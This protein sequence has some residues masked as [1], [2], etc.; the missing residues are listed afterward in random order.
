MKKIYDLVIIGAGSAGLSS[1]IYAGRATL[2]TLVIERENIGGQATI[3]DEIANYPGVK[4]TT[5]PKLMQIMRE[6]AEE[7][8]ANLL[9]AE[10]TAVDFSNE[11]KILQTTEEEIHARAVIIAS[12]AKPRKIG[13][14]GEQE[15]TGRGVGYCATCDGEF[16]TGKEVFVIGGGFS[17]AEEALFL[18]RY[19]TKVTIC[20]R[21]DQFSCAQSVVQEV[22]AHP[23]IEVRF[24][25]EIQEVSGEHQI[26]KAIFFNNETK[27][28][29]VH[30]N[31]EGF[32]V[33]VFAGYEPVSE[34]FKNEVTCTPEGY[35]ST[36][37]NMKTNIPGIYAA[38]DIRPKSLKQIVTAVSDGAFAATDAEKYIMTQKHQQGIKHLPAKKKKGQEKTE[39]PPL[40][41][42]SHSKLRS[43]LLDDALCAQLQNILARME[44]EVTLVTIVD[45]SNEK[46]I[47]LRDLVLDL[48]EL[49]ERLHAIVYKKG[50]NPEMEQK[51]NA[52][53]FPV[54]SF[55]N[56]K[57]EYTGV[58]FHGVPGGHELKFSG[59]RTRNFSFNHRSRTIFNKE[60]QYQSSGFSFLS[61]MSRCRCCSTTHCNRKS[62][63]R[64]R[65]D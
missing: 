5:G 39:H 31:K 3:T 53:K 49:G 30:E 60:N 28:T 14:K 35:I 24:R 26:Q 43:S 15:F 61:F 51:V 11:I 4:T 41:K 63:H 42:V 20:I 37:E 48:A 65:D 2:D 38:G 8:G 18:T 32:G 9:K 12:G 33:F 47:E 59:P 13:F 1:A 62:K 55:L 50:E 44:K 21:R 58:K 52:N 46:S 16:F 22:M 36:D 6:Q 34:L 17:A 56:H 54:V 29:Y 64:N 19:A 40:Q 57:G 45:E 7:F 27:E 25:T 10:I 23:K